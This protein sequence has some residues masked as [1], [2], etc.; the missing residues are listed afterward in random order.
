MKKLLTLAV[1]VGI[2]GTAVA[3]TVAVQQLPF[4]SGTP[5]STG[6]TTATSNLPDGLYYAPQYLPGFPTAATI[7]PRV[8]DVKCEKL[9]ADDVKCAGYNWLPEYGR[10]EYLLIRPTIVEPVP[11]TIVE[12]IV[13]EPA[14]V[15]V[16]KKKKAE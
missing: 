4:G 16:I 3:G 14:P 5:G 9:G 7:W 12:V 6:A 13:K 8:V 2:A 10:G 1:M 11:P 15:R